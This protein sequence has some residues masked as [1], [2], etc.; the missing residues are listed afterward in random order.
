M[1]GLIGPLHV[2]N[3]AFF[4]RKTVNLLEINRN[5]GKQPPIT[6]FAMFVRFLNVL[7]LEP[8]L[9]VFVREKKDITY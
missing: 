3:I 7:P 1:S 5:K 8:Y 4:L 6:I 2:Y 9:N